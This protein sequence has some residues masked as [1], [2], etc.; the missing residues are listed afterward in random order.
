MLWREIIAVRSE[1]NKQHVNTLWGL[2]TEFSSVRPGNKLRHRY[3]SDYEYSNG[4]LLFEW[5]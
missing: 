3:A 5:G 4:Y 1:I 2:N